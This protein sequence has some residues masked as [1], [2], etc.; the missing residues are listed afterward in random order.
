MY[1]MCSVNMGSTIAK[2][3][4]YMLDMYTSAFFVFKKL[5]EHHISVSYHTQPCR[6]TQES[7]E[8][9]PV[10]TGR[11]VVSYYVPTNSSGNELSSSDPLSAGKTAAMQE[12]CKFR[13]RV[14]VERSRK[15]AAPSSST[16]EPR[17]P[18]PSWLATVSGSTNAF[19]CSPEQS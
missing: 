11:Y 15:R 9:A 2:N 5:V 3:S 14:I 18:S 16:A 8:S 12:V 1:K 6:G 17:C 7:Y 10:Y 19:K 4:H 13:Y